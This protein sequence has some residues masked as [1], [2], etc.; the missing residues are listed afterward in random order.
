M[1]YHYDA[2]LRKIAKYDN[3]RP[4]PEVLYTEYCKLEMFNPILFSP[5]SSKSKPPFCR[6]GVK[7]YSIN[8]RANFKTEHIFSFLCF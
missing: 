4:C 2:I 7:D 8:Q 6:Y 3:I 5:P 1:R